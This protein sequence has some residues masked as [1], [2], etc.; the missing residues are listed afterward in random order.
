MTAIVGIEAIRLANIVITR[1]GI[2]IDIVGI[3]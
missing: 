3:K 2:I 1:K